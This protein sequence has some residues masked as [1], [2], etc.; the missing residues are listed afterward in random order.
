MLKVINKHQSKWET[1]KPNKHPP[2]G[3]GDT[4]VLVRPVSCMFSRLVVLVIDGL[5]TSAAEN[6]NLEREQGI[7]NDQNKH[8]RQKK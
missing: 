4:T 1:I 3:A 2:I 8:T 5:R 7:S 6:K